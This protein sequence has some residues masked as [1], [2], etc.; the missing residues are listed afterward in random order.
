MVQ[1]T[2]R[3]GPWVQT[4]LLDCGDCADRQWD[5]LLGQL[6]PGMLS[7]LRLN[8]CVPAPTLALRRLS[9]LTDLRLHFDGQL[10]G[11]AN[12]VLGMHQLRR[13]S[14][15][16]LQL[17]VWL[18]RGA[19]GLT[20]L[21]S[22]RLDA[23]AYYQPCVGEMLSLQ[24]LS[25]LRCLEL[26]LPRSYEHGR[27]AL[28]VPRPACFPHLQCHDLRNCDVRIGAASLLFQC[29]PRRCCKCPHL[30]VLRHTAWCRLAWLMVPTGTVCRSRCWREGSSPRAH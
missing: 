3:V 6:P 16:A 30:L 8:Y 22:L 1:L 2:R 26:L 17:P 24:R 14:I 7:S 13:L 4:A 10:G 18:I 9:A 29:G 19:A 25:Q 12:A 23:E 20:Q 27:N 15:S 5:V 28:L 21:T 11:G